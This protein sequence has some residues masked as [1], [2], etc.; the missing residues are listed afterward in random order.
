MSL[1]YYF[2]GTQCIVFGGLFSLFVACL[3]VC[4]KDYRKTVKNIV[5]KL[6]EH[7]GNGT[8]TMQLH[9]ESHWAKIQITAP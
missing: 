7:I 1:V 4:L 3:F 2:F 9:F 8:G 5:T 6:S